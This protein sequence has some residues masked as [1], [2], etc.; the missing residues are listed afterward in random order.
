MA[1]NLEHSDF[2]FPNEKFLATGA[3]VSAEGCL[4]VRV[5]QNGQEVVQQS[6]GVGGELVV[7]FS[8]STRLYIG[9]DVQIFNPVVVPSVAPYTISTQPM[10]QAGQ[11]QV[12]N[13]TTLVYYTN[14]SPAVPTAG[15]Y[16]VN[17]TTGVFTFA[18]AD[19]GATLQILI[20]F[21]LTVQQARTQNREG[22]LFNARAF[23]TYGKVGV[24]QGKGY[25]YTDQFDV[26]QNYSTGTLTTGAGGIVTIG[27]GGTAL[28]A[29]VRV[30]A[31]PTLDLPFLGLEFNL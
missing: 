13:L 6:A 21:N 3:T 2:L 28:P 5:F 14:V 15:Q 4:L 7:G 29:S 30:I 11:E 1:Y 10:I 9:Q 17:E 31:L 20:K 16:S 12:Q 19:A 26:S 23:E 18:A 22:F 24:I 8:S 25:I 27:G